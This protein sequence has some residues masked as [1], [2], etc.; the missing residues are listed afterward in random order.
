MNGPAHYIAAEDLV[1]EADTLYHQEDVEGS[2][3][4]LGMAEVHAT[5]ALAAA[6]V[7]DR[8]GSSTRGDWNQAIR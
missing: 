1:A 3:I 8:M 7:H 4:V 5:L 2:V 6:T